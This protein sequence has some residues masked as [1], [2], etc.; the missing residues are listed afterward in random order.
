MAKRKTIDLDPDNG[1]FVIGQSGAYQEPEIAPDISEPATPEVKPGVAVPEFD[2]R[3]D[4][5]APP[6]T[7]GDIRATRDAVRTATS[8]RVIASLCKSNRFVAALKSKADALEKE[9]A[10]LKSKK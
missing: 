5:H 3:A 9:L 4:H 6:T 2:P 8:E 10:A 7:A 1:G